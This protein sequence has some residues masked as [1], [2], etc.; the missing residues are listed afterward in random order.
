MYLSTESEDIEMISCQCHYKWPLQE[1][2]NKKQK[3][4]LILATETTCSSSS[5]IVHQFIV[6]AS[7]VLFCF[8]ESDPTGKEKPPLSVHAYTYLNSLWTLCLWL[9]CQGA[10]SNV[11]GYHLRVEPHRDA[12]IGL[13]GIQASLF[14]L[15]ICQFFVWE[16]HIYKYWHLVTI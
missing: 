8:F 12:V 14:Y 3:G 16:I 11:I 2:I 13:W 15:F 5:Y 4:F 9:S 1:K 6:E 7:C 10:A